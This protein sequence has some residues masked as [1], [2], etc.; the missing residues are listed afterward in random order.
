M[1]AIQVPEGGNRLWRRCRR[2]PTNTFYR[3]GSDDVY[4]Q[5]FQKGV[6]TA[7][8]T[9]LVST[10]L[11]HNLITI[12]TSGQWLKFQYWSYPIKL[13]LNL[14]D[15]AYWRNTRHKT[16]FYFTWH[17]LYLHNPTYYKSLSMKS[18]D[19]F[20]NNLIWSI[21]LSKISSHIPDNFSACFL[22]ETH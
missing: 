1:H 17:H 4:T 8:I 12:T 11:L 14:N 18:F 6:Y 5:L 13:S 19:L 15:I 3:K 10:P 21:K 22:H 16:R 20:K 9:S 7:T 2:V